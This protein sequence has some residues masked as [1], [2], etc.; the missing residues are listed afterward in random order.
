MTL[1][2]IS[3]FNS[4]NSWSEWSLNSCTNSV[5]SIP[6]EISQNLMM[7]FHCNFLSQF[8]HSNVF[9]VWWAMIVDCMR[10]CSLAYHGWITMY[11]AEQRRIRC[12]SGSRML[13]IPPSRATEMPSLRSSSPLRLCFTLSDTKFWFSSL[14][15]L[16]YLSALTAPGCP[17]TPPPRLVLPLEPWPSKSPGSATLSLAAQRGEEWVTHTVDISTIASSERFFS[18]NWAS[19]VASESPYVL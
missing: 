6:S 9:T 2:L 8:D 14:H 17:S 18:C 13:L 11:P 16:P 19:P 7:I 1:Q 15:A 10:H 5:S 3:V 4:S 12:L